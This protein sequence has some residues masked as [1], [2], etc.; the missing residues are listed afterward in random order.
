MKILD[1]HIF[2]K[3]NPE[4]GHGIGDGILMLGVIQGVANANP[5]AFVR[6][7]VLEGREQWVL[8]GWPH[9]VTVDH[10]LKPKE[11][12]FNELWPQ[13]H[14]SL[15]GDKIAINRGLTRQGLWAAEVGVKAAWPAPRIPETA[16]AWARKIQ[17]KL[18][19]DKPVVWISPWACA[20]ERTWPLRRWAELAEGLFAAGYAVAGIHCGRE[21]LLDGVTWFEDTAFP[22]DR[23]AAMFERA[24]LVIGNDSGMVHLTGFLNVPA[25]AICGPTR[26]DVIFGDYPSVR[27]IDSPKTC[28]GCLGLTDAYKPRWCRLSCDALHAIQARDVLD[29]ALTILKDLL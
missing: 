13:R 21:F 17:A 19:D 8:L 15:G 1:V 9:V 10:N 29:V 11:P 24:S 26:G 20:R 7:V 5:G 3:K 6:A 25:L 28:G 22:A 16:R 27:V 23:T 14:E 2:S 12:L 4:H 18:F